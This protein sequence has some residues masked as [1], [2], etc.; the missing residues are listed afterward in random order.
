VSLPRRLQYINKNIQVFEAMTGWTYA[1]W[2]NPKRGAE[3]V[4]KQFAKGVDIIFAAAGGT[5]LGV[6]Q[7]AK[8]EGKYAIGVDSNQNYLQPG[9]MLTSMIK[10]A[11]NA[12]YR[13]LKSIQ[14]GNFSPDVENFGLKEG[15]I[16]WPLDQYN[17]SLVPQDLENKINNIKAKI[18]TG[19][20]II[21]DYI[22]DNT[23]Q[24]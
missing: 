18:I 15:G 1:A 23:C 22:T 24:Y 3:L 5:G 11:G 16:D 2:S 20:I 17:R 13:T 4:K 12:T 19:E 10:T 14:A 7:A 9:V 6:Y 8:D 21:H